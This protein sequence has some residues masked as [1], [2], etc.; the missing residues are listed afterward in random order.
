MAIAPPMPPAN[1]DNRLTVEQ[2][3]EQYAATDVEK[4]NIF[5]RRMRTTYPQDCLRGCIRYLG[6]GAA[7][8]Q[9]SRQM[10]LWLTSAIEYMHPLF[11]PQTLAFAAAKA[12]AITLHDAD[13]QFFAKLSRFL[14]DPKVPTPASLT[15]RVLALAPSLGECGVFIPWLRTLAEDP[16][17][18]IRLQSAK[19]LCELRPTRAMVERQLQSSDSQTRADA[20]EAMWRVPGSE[21]KGIFQIAMSDSDHRVVANALV[22]LYLNQDFTSIT[23]LIQMAAGSSTRAKLA[24][25]AAMQRVAD[26]RCI[27][28]LETL[29]ED[30]NQAVC[31]AA[32]TALETFPVPE[33]S[34]VPV[35]A[36][37]VPSEASKPEPE[38]KNSE[39]VVIAFETPAFRLL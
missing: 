13:P 12:A 33:V 29:A 22:G 7:K 30:Q 28:A 19:L 34:P 1:T 15:K 35:P 36:P 5:F 18:Q 24:S 17:E 11:D 25:I 8:E 16:D 32:K 26:P 3:L 31:K 9:V 38:Q 20:L 39:P 37:A 23:K 14:L 21:A 27:P 2:L 10:L 6:T 4:F